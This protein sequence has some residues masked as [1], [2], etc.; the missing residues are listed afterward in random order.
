MSRVDL[1]MND[2]SEQ[3]GGGDLDALGAAAEEYIQANPPG[4][5]EVPAHP[6]LRLAAGACDCVAVFVL[7]MAASCTLFGCAFAILWG[8]ERVAIAKPLFVMIAS[9]VAAAY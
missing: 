9:L 6:A 2:S 8:L 1:G 5:V 7:S 4:G 3:A